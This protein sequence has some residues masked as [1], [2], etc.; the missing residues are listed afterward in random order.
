MSK[1]HLQGSEEEHH[2]GVGQRS[3]AHVFCRKLAS[4][5]CSACLSLKSRNSPFLR[6]TCLNNLVGELEAKI[7]LKPGTVMKTSFSVNLCE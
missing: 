4:L 2:H 3:Y 5:G 1:E 7:V 6:N